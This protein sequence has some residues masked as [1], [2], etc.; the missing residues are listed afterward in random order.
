MVRTDINRCIEEY[1]N[2]REYYKF[3]G[4]ELINLPDRKKDRPENRFIK[5]HN[6]NFYK[7]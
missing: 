1:Q 5:W 4:Q 6:A 7:G 3:H 2:R